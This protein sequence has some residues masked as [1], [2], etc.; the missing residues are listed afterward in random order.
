MFFNAESDELTEETYMKCGEFSTFKF[1]LRDVVFLNN[2]YFFLIQS[3]QENS[4]LRPTYL[5]AVGP[6]GFAIYKS[7]SV[8]KDTLPVN[9]CF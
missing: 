1:F 2:I 8:K 9:Q 4:M 3:S 7:G 6:S 5:I